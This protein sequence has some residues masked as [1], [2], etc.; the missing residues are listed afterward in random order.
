MK[1]RRSESRQVAGDK[2]SADPADSSTQSA[3]DSAP[4]VSTKE[5]PDVQPT[6]SINGKLNSKTKSPTAMPAVTG[7]AGS[8][9]LSTIYKRNR[10]QHLV[11]FVALGGIMALDFGLLGSG[12]SHHMTKTFTLVQ[13]GKEFLAYFLVLLCNLAVLPSILLEAN[14]VEITDDRLILNNLLFRTCL[15]WTDITAVIAPIYLKFAIIKTKRF[16]YLLNKRDINHFQDL[17]NTI[18][19]KVG[20]PAN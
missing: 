7:D 12:I 1:K 20:A 4:E 13:L 6:T 19:E 11:R 16:F 18:R 8:R 2:Q 9:Q 17:I 5:Q 3:I 14:S 10:W 15:P